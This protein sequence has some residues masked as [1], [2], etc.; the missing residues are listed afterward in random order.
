[1]LSYPSSQTWG[2]VLALSLATAVG[3]ASNPAARTPAPPS[4]TVGIAV[5]E[6]NLLAVPVALNLDGIPGIDGFVIKIFASSRKRPKPMP[7]EKGKIEVAMFDGM[8]GRTTDAGNQPL[9]IWT[10][11]V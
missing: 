11:S 2:I 6:I 10:F 5:D 3:C 7:I 1:M 9:R 4:E 8:P